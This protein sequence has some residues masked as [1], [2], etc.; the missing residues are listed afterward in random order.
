VEAKWLIA[1]DGAKSTARGLLQVPFEGMDI[2][3]PVV[4]MIFQQHKPK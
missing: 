3:S 1:A 4:Q 2:S